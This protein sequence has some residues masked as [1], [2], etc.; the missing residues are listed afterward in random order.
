MFITA[1]MPAG[2]FVTFAFSEARARIVRAVGA[3]HVVHTA[4]GRTLAIW[5]PGE[6]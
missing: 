3:P 1:K 6:V 5:L 4:G 2:H